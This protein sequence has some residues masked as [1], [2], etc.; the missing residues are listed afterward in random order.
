MT[1][2]LEINYKTRCDLP[3]DI[4]EHLP[5]LKKYADECDHIT[6]MGV[7]WVVSTFAFMAGLPKKLISYDIDPLE[8][9][10]FKTEEVIEL[11]EKNGI[12]FHFKIANTLDLEIEETDLLFLDTDH[13]YNQVKNE[14][15]LHGNKSKKYIIFHDTTTFEFKGMN[16]DT[17]GLWPAIEEFMSEN[18]HWVICERFHNNNGLTILK[19]I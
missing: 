13:T 18:P 14:L 9:W 5:T 3:S 2:E 6:E 11:A 1:P 19:R 10:G 12:E 15:L 7:R 17:I 8:N 4:N 16:G